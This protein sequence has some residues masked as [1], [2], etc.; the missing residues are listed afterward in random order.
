MRFDWRLG[1]LLSVPCTAEGQGERQDR[2]R[3]RVGHLVE[4]DEID[5]VEGV[6][7]LVVAGVEREAS[8]AVPLGRLSAVMMSSAPVNSPPAGIPAATNAS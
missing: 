7:G 8:G 6:T 4:R 5:V 3:H 1:A 2:V